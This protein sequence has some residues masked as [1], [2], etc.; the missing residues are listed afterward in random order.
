MRAQVDSWLNL[1]PHNKEQ[2]LN[3]REKQ[4]GPPTKILVSPATGKGGNSVSIHL[5]GGNG[6]FR[7]DF[8]LDAGG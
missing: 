3:L 4:A 5:L 8:A 1:Q 7:Q 2:Q 6:R